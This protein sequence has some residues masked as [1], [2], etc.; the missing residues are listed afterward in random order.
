VGGGA[1]ALAP[2]VLTPPSPAAVIVLRRAEEGD[3]DAIVAIERAS[4]SDPWPRGAFLS[5]I[6]R[7]DADVVVA[8]EAAEPGPV[9]DARRPTPDALLGYA[10]A[11]FI[12]GE[13]EVGNVAVH[14]DARGRGIGARLLDE[15]L[16]EAGRRDAGVMFLEVRESNDAAR[17]LYASRGFVQVGRRRRYY[18]R[19]DEDALVMRWDRG[20]PA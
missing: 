10:I 2:H 12:V 6:R 4:F 17:R 18:R 5:L 20:S 1:R 13:G 16:A 11:W 19:P 7:A 9:P 8:V 15:A 14:P 3:L